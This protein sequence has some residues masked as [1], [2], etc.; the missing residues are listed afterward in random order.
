MY[1]YI[2]SLQGY[3]KTE[4]VIITFVATWTTITAMAN[5]KGAGL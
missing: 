4:E 1:I 3:I 5:N 2:V